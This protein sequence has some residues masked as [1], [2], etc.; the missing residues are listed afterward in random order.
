[1][2]PSQI[3]L[4]WKKCQSHKVST[5]AIKMHDIIDVTFSYS[6]KEHSITLSFVFHRTVTWSRFSGV[7]LWIKYKNILLQEAVNLS[8]AADD[9]LCSPDFGEISEVQRP[10][11]VD[12]FHSSEPPWAFSSRLWVA[13]SRDAPQCLQPTS[14]FPK[15]FKD[16]QSY[17]DT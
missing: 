9:S 10:V 7:L 17:M 15:D 3:L 2:I 12:P 4:C 8:S 13:V 6:A 1:M 5:S 11:T 14:H 16:A